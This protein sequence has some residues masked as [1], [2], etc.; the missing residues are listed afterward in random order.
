MPVSDVDRAKAF[1]VDG[2]GFHCDVD[3]RAGEDFRVVQLTPPGSACSVTLMRN[4]GAAGSLQ[5][6][7]LVVDDLPAARDELVARGRRGERALPLRDAGPAARPAPGA[8]LARQLRV[9]QRPRRHRLAAAGG[10]PGLTRQGG[11]DDARPAGAGGA[12]ATGLEPR[13]RQVGLPPRIVPAVPARSARG[14][15]A[16]ACPRAAGTPR[17][18]GTPRDELTDRRARPSR[19]R[20]GP[21]PGPRAPARGPTARGSRGGCRG[22]GRRGRPRC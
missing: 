17:A 18:G 12:G 14:A 3:H 9:R 13:A 11:R 20:A 10:T 22:R 19:G 7:H 5:G 16:T 8:G 4:E 6:L 21:A 2:M 1:Y 15:P